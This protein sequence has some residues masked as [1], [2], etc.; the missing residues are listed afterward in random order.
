VLLDVRAAAHRS[1]GPAASFEAAVNVV[2]S[3]GVAL[4]RSGFVLSV[5]RENGEPLVPSGAPPTESMVLDAL[6]TVGTADDDGLDGA[7]ERLRRGDWGGVLVCVLGALDPSQAERLAR[8]R[9]GS[10]VCVAVVLDTGSWAPGGARDRAASVERAERVN[11][12]LAGAGWRV[13]PLSYGTELAALWS[14]AGGRVG[15]TAPQ[16]GYAGSLPA[17]ATGR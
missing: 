8:L 1:D 11:A 16:D 3:I 14:S 9:T 4:A 15:R 17:G 10:S 6:A 7:V 12:L 2:A 5:L 13:L